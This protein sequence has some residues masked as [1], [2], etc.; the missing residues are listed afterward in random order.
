MNATVLNQEG[1]QQTLIM[2]CY[3]MGITRMVAAIIEQKHD[4]KGISWPTSVAPLDVHLLALNYHKSEAVKNAADTLYSDL[5]AAGFT[6]LLDDRKERP[7][8]KFA[9]ADLLGLPHR[10][11]VGDR[12]LADNNIEY[13]R[14]TEADSRLLPLTDAI[15]ALS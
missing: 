9:D 14:R 11:T 10:I 15:A 3:G 4:D 8:V 13:Q 5:L 1:R 12:N 7:G 2:G 6:V